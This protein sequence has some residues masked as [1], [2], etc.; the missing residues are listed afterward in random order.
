MVSAVIFLPVWDE[1]SEDL[2]LGPL[3]AVDLQLGASG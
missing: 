2:P 3:D 1:P